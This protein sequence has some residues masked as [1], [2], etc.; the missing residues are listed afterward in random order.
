MPS[1]ELPT[2]ALAVG[3][4]GG[5]GVGCGRIPTASQPVAVSPL[6]REPPA[7]EGGLVP[8]QCEL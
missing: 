2:Q 7:A 8:S 3:I 5:V 6:S 4:E 1:P